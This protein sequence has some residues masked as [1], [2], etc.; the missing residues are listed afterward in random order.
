MTPNSPPELIWIPSPS[1][2]IWIPTEDGGYQ[3]VPV[4]FGGKRPDPPPGYVVVPYDGN[5]GWM[6]VPSK[7]PLAS[8]PRTPHPFTE[9]ELRMFRNRTINK[10]NS[11]FEA[12]ENII[13]LLAISEHI[14]ILRSRGLSEE[15]FLKDK[16]YFEINSIDH[17]LNVVHIINLALE[18]ADKIPYEKYVIWCKQNKRKRSPTPFG[19]TLKEKL[20]YARQYISTI[21]G[22]S[23][24]LSNCVMLR[25]A[26]RYLWG[27]SYS[28]AFDSSSLEHSIAQSV[29]NLPKLII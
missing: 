25:D 7:S 20:M 16:W 13:K 24:Q 15:S 10:W 22:K 26:E 4:Y 17:N 29:Y 21:R 2:L 12:S 9:E 3:Q 23:M 11:D 6:I 19:P 28:V 18:I 5:F 27:L 8:P 1:E 14:N